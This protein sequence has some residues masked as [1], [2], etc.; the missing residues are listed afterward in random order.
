MPQMTHPDSKQTIE[1]SPSEVDR[2]LTQGWEKK[3]AAK[4]SDKAGK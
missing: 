3:T 1:V 4:S 2:Y